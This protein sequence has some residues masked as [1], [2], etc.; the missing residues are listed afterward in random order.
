[1]A[2]NKVRFG[3]KNVHYALLSENST[4]S[5]PEWATPV[6]VPGA[7][8][9]DLSA[10]SAD[11]N[12][13]A[14]NIA[15]F[16]S[17]ANNGYSGSLELAFIPDAMKKDVFGFQEESTDKVIY[18]VATVDPKPFALLFQIDGDANDDCFVLYRCYANRPNIG[19][20]TISENGKDPQTQS[21]DISVLPLIDNSTAATMNNVI[22]AKTTSATT[23][24]VKTG[25]FSAV[26][27][28]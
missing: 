6:A 17:F 9:L 21:M 20:E 16:K 5:A 14:D 24:T 23:S 28:L 27:E 10:E 2:E 4:T 7:V 8:S 12:F 26:W 22:K 19:S 11:V 13:Y 15:Y 25:W 1:M 18:E 3:L